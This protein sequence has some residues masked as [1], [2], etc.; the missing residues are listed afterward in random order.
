[1]LETIKEQFSKAKTLSKSPYYRHHANQSGKSTGELFPFS[2]DYFHEL[3]PAF[4]FKINH[5]DLLKQYSAVTVRDGEISFGEFILK[6]HQSVS[7]IKT[8]FIIHPDLAQIVPES[9][10]DSFAVWNIVHSKTI[11]VTQAKRILILGIMNEQTLPSIE[12]IKKELGQLKAISQN[13]E[14]D[15]Y[16]PVRSHPFGLAW[17]ESFMGYQIIETLKEILPKNKFNYLSHPELMEKTSCYGT[18]CLDLMTRKNVIADSFLNHLLSSRGATISSFDT[19]D[20]KNNFFEIDLSLGHK[21][22][23]SPLPVVESVFPEMIF[24]KK[25]AATSDYAADPNFHSLFRKKNL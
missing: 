2:V 20:I 10:K 11:Q 7:K 12:E 5:I 1:M 22:Q 13:I 4:L 18:Y 24:Y 25:Q 14:I 21:I 8:K 23:F 9:I 3:N 16:L 17:K 6:N 15:I 19:A